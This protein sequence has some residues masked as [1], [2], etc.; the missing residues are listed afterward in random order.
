MATWKEK[1][2]VPDSDEE[3][4]LDS[5]SLAGFEIH[6]EE[7]H[8]NPHRLDDLIEE[9]EHEEEE[10]REEHLKDGQPTSSANEIATTQLTRPLA[11]QTVAQ[12][13]FIFPPSSPDSPK[14]FK[15]P[16]TFWEL[17]EDED[18]PPAAAKLSEERTTSDEI[19]KSYVRI[20]SPTSSILSSLPASQLSLPPNVVQNVSK[21]GLPAKEDLSAGNVQGTSNFGKRSLRQRNPIQLHPYIVEQERYQR[22]LK[23]RGVAP[24]RLVQSQDKS[25]S[26]SRDTASPDP[27]SQRDSQDVEFETG[28]SQQMDFN[29]DPPLSSS[30]QRPAED[31]PNTGVMDE[32]VAM[33]DDD[34]D[35][36]FPDIDELL[37]E[38]KRFPSTVERKG[39]TKTYSSKSKRP[40]L[41][42][43]QTES[44][45]RLRD[46]RAT[47]DIFNVPASPPTTSPPFPTTSRHARQSLSRTAS[48]TSKEPTPIRFNFNERG[49]A[50]DLPTPVTSAAKAGSGPV[51]IQSD[52]DDPFA[53]DVEAGSL[54]SSSDESVQIRKVSKKIRGVLPASHLRLD[55][56]QKKTKPAPVFR[57]SLSLSPAKTQARRGVAL[58]RFPGN[59][60]SPSVSTD[61]IA[62]LSDDSE[63]EDEE[64]QSRGFIMEDDTRLELDSLF[65]QSRIGFA[66]EDDRIDAMLPSLKRHITSSNNPRKKQRLGSSSLYG[67]GKLQPK[68]TGH[69]SR[70]RQS[71][72]P[73]SKPSRKPKHPSI[74][75]QPAFNKAIS[76]P[77]SPAPPRLSIL[78]IAHDPGV[79]LPQFIKVAARAARS[80]KRQGRQSPSRK[81][82]RLSNRED[83]Q[84]VQSVLDDWKGGRIKPKVLSFERSNFS[85]SPEGP[86]QPIQ[87]NRQTRLR[88][89]ESIA[90]PSHRNVTIGNV[91]LPR[92]LVVS[93][94]KQRSMNDFVSKEYTAPQFPGP[95]SRHNLGSI[96]LPRRER[97]RYQHPL[98]RPAQLES[99][100]VE[101]S[102]RNPATAFK[103][104]K[105]ALDVLY[106]AARKRP[107]P[108]ANL[109]L[110]RFLADEDVVRPSVENEQNDAMSKVRS[111]NP[112]TNL[113]QISQRRKKRSPQRIDAGA[114]MYRQPS[115]PLILEYLAPAQLPNLDSEG[116]KLLGLAKFGTNYPCNFD[117]LPLQPGVFFHESTL[118][119]SGRLAEVLKG[120]ISPNQRP[121]HPPASLQLADKTFCWE[122]WDENASSEVGLCF[123]W[124]LDQLIAQD[125]PVSSPRTHAIAITNFVYDYVLNHLNFAGKLDQSNFLSRMK[126]V[127]EEFSSRI[128]ANQGMFQDDW[129]KEAIE[130]LSMVVL[131]TLRLLQM[132]HAQ[133]GQD[134]LTY[135]IE[136]LLK[137][138]SAHLIK[139]LMDQGLDG[140]RKLYDDLQYLS[141]RERGIR[142]DQY[143][144]QG[145][146]VV[147]KVLQAAKIPRGSFWD[148][149][150]SKLID[151][152]VKDIRDA[153]MM[154]KLWYSMFSLLPLCEFDEFGVVISGQRQEVSFEN[155]MLPQLLS[156][157]VF[158]LYSLNPRQFPGFND[159]CRSIVGRCHH[160]MVEW[161][162]WKCSGVIGTL[163]DFFA[164][165]NLSHLRNEEAYTSPRFL[166]E[167]AT[168]PSLAVELEDRCFHIFL[169]LVALSIQ[170]FRLVGDDKNI[171]NLVAR[172]LPNHNRQYPKEESVH[173]RDLASLRNHHDLLCTLFWS[174]PPEL[175]PALSLLQELVIADRSHKEACLINLRAWENLACFILTHTQNPEAFESFTAW[176]NT[177]STKLL[178]QYF[179]TESEVRQQADALS[180]TS[181]EPIT[182]AQ[183]E[184][185]IT[186]NETNTLL[187][188]QRVLVTIRRAVAV[189]PSSE[190]AKVAFNNSRL[191]GRPVRLSLTLSRS[192]LEHHQHHHP[193]VHNRPRWKP[194]CC[195]P[196]DPS[197][198]C[199]LQY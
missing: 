7:R 113:I 183:L 70:P 165:Q 107:V 127:L 15:A 160:L 117:I 62:F 161:G 74:R 61:P 145:W 121:D 11:T 65:T 93:R 34:D 28:E 6:N 179:D 159:Y 2:E 195:P 106:R 86:L 169:K 24:I 90:K 16:Q 122:S 176:Q 105:R 99:Y 85:D 87:N 27:D 49:I 84:D 132:A 116:S 63:E 5:Q 4:S 45:P 174:A 154:E 185:T 26:R 111:K 13:R 184:A 162:W 148:V 125:T 10:S 31:H 53:S 168:E 22:T 137:A 139:T 47:T 158:E 94:G 18:G 44:A 82:I 36:E 17:E 83:T 150:N 156:K 68:I 35:D 129:A 142:N 32:D 189:A 80:R 138:L 133:Q 188:L 21:S 12:D 51:L 37:R 64:N 115:D 119:G 69:L 77:R 96:L 55:Q 199:W 170:H 98:P 95:I 59:P 135:E 40:L 57:N 191:N 73:S 126:E 88:S 58:P 124:I 190:L 109:Q 172:L 194:C 67:K 152:N 141:Y 30:P 193:P 118:I 173:Q 149:T 33:R 79:R 123:D 97:A 128:A 186:A 147:I 151:V 197:Q 103:T 56:Q 81:F 29:W 48:N 78:D 180:K 66:E 131:L 146:V 177:F 14:L 178:Q 54:A 104:T 76:Q 102:S 175:R 153:R 100:E 9:Q 20:T 198:K 144:V 164:S 108:Q 3:D 157:R 192:D 112:F 52:S 43:I 130:M 71:T 1:G 134:S 110:S 136:D 46:R 38:P 92:K 182:E 91:G 75:R 120:I 171:R 181:K 155:W 196:T 39:R 25:H 41:S 89:P 101:Y 8:D 19:S 72:A 23:A 167:L 140:I 163:F 60:Q 166:E 187:T 42:K 143:A 50:A 114:A